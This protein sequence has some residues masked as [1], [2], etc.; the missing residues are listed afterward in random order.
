M[1][2]RYTVKLVDAY[3]SDKWMNRAKYRVWAEFYRRSKQL[4]IRIN[5]LVWC[6]EEVCKELGG[7]GLLEAQNEMHVFMRDAE[8]L[9]P[10]TLVV[11]PITKRCNTYIGITE[12][13]DETTQCVSY[14]KPFRLSLEDNR[15]YIRKDLLGQYDENFPSLNGGVAIRR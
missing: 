3:D 2:E 9:N 8:V 5:P 14:Y 11:G 6:V 7:L 1:M 13:A 4:E 15:E 12:A 10:V